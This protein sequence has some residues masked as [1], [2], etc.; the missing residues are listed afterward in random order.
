MLVAHS[1]NSQH[2]ANNKKIPLQSCTPKKF[3]CPLFFLSNA[4]AIGDPIKLA[5]L[6]TLH[7]MPRRVPR[8]DK[9][10][11]MLAKAADGSVTNGAER[12]PK[13]C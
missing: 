10:G 2:V 5:M 12:K 1:T 8:F 7:D 3:V 11:Q 4:P 13:Q 9:S 6:E